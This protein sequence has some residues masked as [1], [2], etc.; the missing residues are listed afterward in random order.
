M[1][2]TDVKLRPIA[3]VPPRTSLKQDVDNLRVA[4][5]R[6]G[7]DRRPPLLVLRVHNAR[8]S[9][10]TGL[11]KRAHHL[12]PPPQRKIVRTLINPDTRHKTPDSR[13]SLCLGL[14]GSDRDVEER[15]A[16]LVAEG[17]DRREVGGG[18]GSERGAVAGLRGAEELL[19][20]RPAL[21]ARSGGGGSID[22][23][24]RDHQDRARCCWAGAGA[25]GMATGGARSD[26]K[27]IRSSW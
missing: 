19:I 25:I 1:C 21:P 6:R 22:V 11:R 15:A 27:I 10:A 12:N 5:A 3:K 16:V 23:H 13:S 18:E 26:G 2:S 20:R 9:V 24:R 7:V 8:R 14:A 17:E 4:G